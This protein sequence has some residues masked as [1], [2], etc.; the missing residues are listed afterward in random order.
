MRKF[1][2]KASKQ[3]TLPVT[4]ESF[5]VSYCRRIETVNI[6][7]VGD[8]NLPG[9]MALGTFKIN[10]MFPAQDYAFAFDSGDPYDYVSSIKKIIT[11]KKP[12]RFIVSGTG[13]NERVLIE[14]I[15]YGERD[16]TGD[17]YAT[18]TMRGYR[19]VSATQTVATPAQ[20]KAS[21]NRFREPDQD[22]FVERIYYAKKGQTFYEICRAVYGS[23]S[24]WGANAI[25][26]ANYNGYGSLRMTLEKDMAI[27]YP[28]ISS[29]VK[30]AY[31]DLTGAVE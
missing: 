9:G 30:N 2:I 29:L 1:I 14:D 10:C 20:P 16:G 13:V 6:H 19:V 26:L 23:G 17:V 27:K 28:P 8:V 24:A 5:E 18:I 12:V 25:R 21:V 22:D 7:D 31:R 4:P 11:K 15:V 3:L